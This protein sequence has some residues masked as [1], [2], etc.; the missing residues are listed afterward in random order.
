MLP[1]NT[2][3]GRVSSKPLVVD[4]DGTL[5]NSDLLLES[6]VAFLRG[7]PLR[8]YRPLLWL[9]TG[10]KANLKAGIAAHTPLDI[11][12][13]PFNQPVLDW[14]IDE[15][16]RGRS[17]VLATAS[18]K[19]YAE[20]VGKHLGIFDRIFASTSELNLSA[21]N[22]RAALVDEYGE[23]GF[24]YAGNA[25]DDLKVWAAAD[26]AIVVNPEAGVE[27]R[28]R[29]QGNVIKVIDTRAGTAKAWI[30]ALRLHQWLKNLLIFMPLFAA[31]Q[32]TSMPLLINAT[33][34]FLLFSIC[35][36]SVY[37]LNDI[38]DLKEDRRHS[39]KRFRPFAA[40][41][42]PVKMGFIV[43]PLLLI[44]AF[45]ASFWLLPPAFSSALALY[46]LA[47]LS[48][49]ML[50]KRIV[51]ADVV[52]LASLYTI[53]IIAGAL[54]CGLM[55]TFWLLGF[56]M[57]IFF[58]L[59]LVK[60]YAELHRAKAEGKIGKT[61]GRGYYPTDLEMISSLG[62]ASGY[63]SVMVLA[64]YIQEQGI[65]HL[66]RHPQFIW[67]AC[68]ILMFWISRTWMLTHRGQMHDDPVVFAVKDKVSLAT[69]A[70]LFLVFWI[71]A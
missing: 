40:G 34:A 64:L 6:G 11:S 71:A 56:S 4:L 41:T 28:A 46:Y 31:H 66:Y 65:A 22:K 30:K 20:Q 52:M 53:R 26:G 45:T 35:A 36:S 43:F 39:T 8:F 48:Y 47:T 58:S 5:L 50:I 70:L 21:G 62:A 23:R 51:V 10:G 37:L 60:R 1:V 44:G 13:L 2:G 55:L 14:L 54:A 7:N 49:S 63:L 25:N 67:I 3:D 61:S 59:A 42:I 9:L 69:G 57:F 18:H 27:Q 19:S 68:P 24:D 15:K 33:L 29:T 32:F 16:A 17:L 38:L 12:L